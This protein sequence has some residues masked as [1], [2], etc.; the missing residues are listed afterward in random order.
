L[1]MTESNIQESVA[2]IQEPPK[3]DKKISKIKEFTNELI[4]SIIIIR[5]GLMNGLG[6]VRDKDNKFFFCSFKSF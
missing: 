1:E 6:F 5:E 2:F 3:K 4:D